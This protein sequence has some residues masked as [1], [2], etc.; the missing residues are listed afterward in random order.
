MGTWER[1]LIGLTAAMVLLAPA[2]GGC[3]SD[4]SLSNIKLLPQADAFA[5]S[6]LSYSGRREEFALAPAAP[7][8]LVGADGQCASAGSGIEPP[9]VTSN[10][11]A[12]QMTECE[13]VRRIGAPE[14][15]N[16]G[17]NDRGERE[18][19]LTYVNGQRPGI[20]RFRSGR[21]V[22]IERGPEPVS[23]ARPHRSAPKA[24]RRSSS[25]S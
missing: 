21:L 15:L 14:Q 10:G 13:I 16:V 8:D 11:V 7:I 3:S 18:V 23:A 5:A 24:K 17:G 9:S 4:M 22:S 20:Y 2:I 25:N 6:E 12:L 19:L 1:N